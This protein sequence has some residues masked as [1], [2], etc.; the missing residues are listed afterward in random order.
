MRKV[1]FSDKGATH[2]L[3]PAFLCLS[4]TTRPTFFGQ[5]KAPCSAPRCRAQCTAH[6]AALA[7]RSRQDPLTPQGATWPRVAP[8]AASSDMA[9]AAVQQLEHLPF[10][11]Q[12]RPIDGVQQSFKFQATRVRLVIGAET[13]THE[14]TRDERTQLAP[15]SVCE[16]VRFDPNEQIFPT[17]A[18]CPRTSRTSSFSRSLSGFGMGPPAIPPSFPPKALRSFL[19]SYCFIVA[20]DHPL[21]LPRTPAPSPQPHPRAPGACSILLLPRRGYRLR[22]QQRDQRK[23]S[24][25]TL[26]L[27]SHP[28]TPAPP[29]AVLPSAVQMLA[30]RAHAPVAAKSALHALPPSRRTNSRF[31]SSTSST[32]EVW[33]GPSPVTVSLRCLNAV[34]SASV[35]PWQPSAGESTFAR[36]ARWLARLAPEL[37]QPSARG[38]DLA[39]DAKL[40]SRRGRH[41]AKEAR[42]RQLISATIRGIDHRSTERAVAASHLASHTASRARARVAARSESRRALASP[43]ALSRIGAQVAANAAVSGSLSNAA[44]VESTTTTTTRTETPSGTLVAMTISSLEKAGD[45]A[46]AIDRRKS[47]LVKRES[48]S[49]SH[50]VAQRSTC[51]LFPRPPRHLSDC[52]ARH[53]RSP[54][55]PSSRARRRSTSRVGLFAHGLDRLIFGVRDHDRPRLV[56]RPTFRRFH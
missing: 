43:S 14:F 46:S 1:Y 51:S 48:R 27:Q 44:Q 56:I 10:A 38:F 4:A 30:R 25:P 16:S 23:D 19:G 33:I 22:F 47:D 55:L 37:D 29:S 28:P 39:F 7:R 15:L 17:W 5:T 50:I 21:H 41:P 36:A 18:C 45:H 52:Q 13:S 26:R 42:V 12:P 2:A 40:L 49:Q 24:P 53:K 20:A 8:H 32:T 31:K 34:S 11:L 3:S 54:Q 6:S 9:P 35:A